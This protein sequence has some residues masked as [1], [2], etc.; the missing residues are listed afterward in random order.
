MARSIFIP[1]HLDPPALRR[2]CAF[3]AFVLRR[4]WFWP[5]MIGMVLITLSLGGLLQLVPMAETSA[6]LMMG[7]GLAVPLVA[8]GLYLILIEAQVARQGLKQKPLMYTLTLTPEGVAVTG[9]QGDHSPVR[10]SWEGLWGA[11][12]RRGCIYLYA[13][14]QRA[15]ILPDGQASAAPEEV[16]RWMVRYMGAGK[17][18]TR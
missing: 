13:T 18:V 15:F 9:A 12:R 14:P 3:D 10:L 7:L 2:F 5:V 11:F 17:C 16:W 6:G 4:R 1:V 8:F